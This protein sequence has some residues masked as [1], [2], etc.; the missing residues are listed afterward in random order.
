MEMLATWMLIM[1]IATPI[2]CIAS[3]I[4]GYNINAPKKILK[5]P[6]KKRQP[7]ADE[8]MLERIENAQVYKTEI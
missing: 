5:L 6:E 2:L 3:F 7:T 8:V 4:I 1:T